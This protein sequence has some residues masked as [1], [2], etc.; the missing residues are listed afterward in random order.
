MFHQDL[1]LLVVTHS[2]DM[3]VTLICRLILFDNWFIRYTSI[4]CVRTTVSKINKYSEIVSLTVL[5]V[6]VLYYA[7]SLQAST[8]N[9]NSLYQHLT[10]KNKFWQNKESE[11]LFSNW[12]TISSKHIYYNNGSR[13]AALLAAYT[14]YL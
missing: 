7:Q 12:A 10:R 13:R 11:S 9:N 6:F 14:D 1:N 4:T 5:T 3:F 2:K 8:E